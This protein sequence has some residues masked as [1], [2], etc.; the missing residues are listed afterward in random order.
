MSSR[1]SSSAR[2]KKTIVHR[3]Q[4][5]RV[6]DVPP[7]IYETLR[8]GKSLT[9]E[10]LDILVSGGSLSATTT[11]PEDEKADH[12][13]EEPVDM[14]L[15]GGSSLLCAALLTPHDQKAQDCAKETEDIG[16]VVP[17]CVSTATTDPAPSGDMM[18][19]TGSDSPDASTTGA[20]LWKGDE[21][22]R[23]QD[24]VG[25]EVVVRSERIASRGS[26]E[27]ATKQQ[28]PEKDSDGPA[29][30]EAV[31]ESGAECAKRPEPPLLPLSAVMTSDETVPTMTVSPES[32]GI[33]APVDTVIT[34]AVSADGDAA[35][36]AVTIKSDAAAG[37]LEQEDGDKD[38]TSNTEEAAAPI[39]SPAVSP[40]LHQPSTMSLIPQRGSSIRILAP[41]AKPRRRSHFF[42]ACFG[43]R[44]AGQ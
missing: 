16:S 7:E 25:E 1:M 4:E 26:S 3:V 33:I 38:E 44:T 29:D 8:E 42:R 17:V 36:V 21:V 9:P 41:E 30:P 10:Q 40:K 19:P 22:Q 35:S 20:E 18:M 37:G 34:C 6:F 32:F 31:S 12:A 11:L 14:L 5:R 2:A 23:E 13:E 28:V 24:D 39:T 27:D 15:S 43:R